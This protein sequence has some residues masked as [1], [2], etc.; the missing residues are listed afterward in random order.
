MEEFQDKVISKNLQSQMNDEDHYLFMK[1][2]EVLEEFKEIIKTNK[3]YDTYIGQGFYPTK[4]PPIVKRHILE[5][6]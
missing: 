3:R 5:N 2:D 4:I 6:P 1:T